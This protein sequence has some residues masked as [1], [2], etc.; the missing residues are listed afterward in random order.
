M[1]HALVEDKPDLEHGE[2]LSPV[3]TTTDDVVAQKRQA[4]NDGEAVQL[5]SSFDNLGLLATV[6]VFRKTALI[7]L[8]AAFVAGTDGESAAPFID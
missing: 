6:K 8:I 4:I 7:C 3:L 1:S 2:H 5:K